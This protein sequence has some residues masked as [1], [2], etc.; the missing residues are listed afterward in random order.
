[1]SQYRE[2]G[3][4]TEVKKTQKLYKLDLDFPNVFK[5]IVIHDVGI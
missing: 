3:G 2:L 4:G 1:M 5:Y